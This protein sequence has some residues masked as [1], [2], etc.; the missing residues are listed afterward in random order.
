MIKTIAIEGFTN[1]KI[2]L[3]YDIGEIA[4]LE[5]DG[6]GGIRFYDRNGLTFS[7][8]AKTSFSRLYAMADIAPN[9]ERNDLLSESDKWVL[10]VKRKFDGL[11]TSDP[12]VIWANICYLWMLNTESCPPDKACNI[13]FITETLN[14]QIPTY[15]AAIE[16]L[17]KNKF[18]PLASDFIEARDE[19]SNDY[20]VLKTPPDADWSK[21][22][23]IDN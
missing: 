19:Y 1:G 15:N 9:T 13:A 17:I 16:W 22:P 21:C 4:K 10:V 6:W 20:G 8:I 3:T 12:R 11:S 5:L 23:T 2:L 18:R 14:A 7:S